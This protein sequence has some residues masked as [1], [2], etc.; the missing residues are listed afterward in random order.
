MYVKYTYIH[1]CMHTYSHAYIQE[2]RVH[3]ARATELV[4]TCQGL[5]RAPT[6]GAEDGTEMA[7]EHVLQYVL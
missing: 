4:C 1:A 5:S 2:G 6:A 3:G 7:G